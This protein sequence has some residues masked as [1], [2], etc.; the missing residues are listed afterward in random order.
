MAIREVRKQ[1]DPVLTKKAKLV[2]KFNDPLLEQLVEDMFE[3]MYQAPGVGLAA[4]QVGISKRVL[5]ADCGEEYGGPYVL[6]NPKIIHSEG[7]QIG[8]EGCLS[9][10]NLYGDVERAY[11]VIVKAQNLKGKWFKI[12]AEKLLSR[13]FQ[14]EIDHL[15][16]ILFVDKATNLRELS[17]EEYKKERADKE[18]QL[19]VS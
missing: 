3:T 8:I 9:F 4:P 18:S 5:V 11:K 19:V 10:P 7:T 2:E 16:G 13:C 14:H 15:D 6:I 12:E 1:G 17:P